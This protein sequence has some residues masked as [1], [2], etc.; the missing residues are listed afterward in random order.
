MTDYLTKRNE[1]YYYMRRVPE[2]VAHIDT[3]KFVR[4]TLKTKDRRDALRKAVIHNDF[5]E[6]YWRSLLINEATTDQTAEYLLAVKRAKLHSFAY[7]S[8]AEIAESPIERIAQRVNTAY[9]AIEEPETVQALLGGVEAPKLR[10]NECTSKYWD[11]CTDRIG[12]KSAHQVRKWKNPRR[13]AFQQFMALLG[14]EKA[15][16]SLSRSDAL[17]FISFL[18]ERIQK[19]E[20][21]SSTANKSLGYVRDI[22]TEV[23]T[24]YE[25]DINFKQLFADLKFKEKVQSRLPFEARYVQ[26]TFISGDALTGLNHEARLLVMAMS[27]TGARESELIGLR[28][29]DIF[30]NEEIPYIWIQSYEGNELKTPS[31]N[32]KIPLVG[33]S[34][35]AFRNLTRGFIH[36]QNADTASSTINKYLR[37]NDL[38]PSAR[39]TLY[40]LRHTFKDRLRD[41]GAPEEV[42]DELMG[43]KKSGPK[44]GR[45]HLIEKKYQWLNEIAF[46]PPTQVH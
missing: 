45:G 38:K 13:A 15:I 5:F 8:I 28:P 17:A 26:E 30:L 36:Y 22:L 35:Y 21:A 25:I 40:S 31:S 2:H 46:L 18:R 42:I 3:R 23:G 6:E 7:R 41:I 11:I 27:D 39:H 29:E 33:A 16:G 32:R 1:I 14:E 34:L 19:K 4:A 10:L 43:H 20:I 12:S 37:E 24:E 44:Y 9:E